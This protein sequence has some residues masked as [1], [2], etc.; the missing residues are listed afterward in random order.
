MDPN[1]LPDYTLDLTSG[2]VPT[3]YLHEAL[4]TQQEGLYLH[5]ELLP[6]P[7]A[8]LAQICYFGGQQVREERDRH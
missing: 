1:N 7:E 8:F 4:D 3:Q 5:A 6:E 2:N